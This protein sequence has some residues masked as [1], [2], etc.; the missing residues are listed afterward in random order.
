M[1]NQTPRQGITTAFG[2]A[3]LLVVLAAV[4]GITLA[5]GGDDPFAARAQ[6]DGDRG[7]ELRVCGA[8]CGFQC[9]ERPRAGNSLQRPASVV[10]QFQRGQKS[11]HR[12]NGFVSPNF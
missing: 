7:P 10:A 3:V 4:V 5:G 1:N 6:G 2:A 11:R 9:C 8:E 12:W